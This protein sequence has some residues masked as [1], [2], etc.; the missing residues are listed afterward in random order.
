MDGDEPRMNKWKMHGI[1]FFFND[2]M[3]AILSVLCRHAPYIEGWQSIVTDIKMPAKT[4]MFVSF[5]HQDPLVRRIMT[6]IPLA[7]KYSVVS[8]AMKSNTVEPRN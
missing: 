2:N 7:N 8:Y 5:R 3:G 4:C 1:F 6:N